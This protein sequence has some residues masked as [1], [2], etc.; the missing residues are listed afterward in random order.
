MVSR[1][2]RDAIAVL[3]GL[4]VCV[5]GW[6]WWQDAPRRAIQEALQNGDYRLA[7]QLATEYLQQYPEDAQINVHAAHACLSLGRRVEA[8]SHFLRG[9]ELSLDDL[10]ARADNLIAMGRK[11][12]AAEVLTLSRQRG[13][14]HFATLQRL[15][16]LQFERGYYKQAFDL[17]DE[18]ATQPGRRRLAQCLKGTF[19]SSLSEHELAVQELLPA[20]D[21]EATA[22]ELGMTYAAAAGVLA[23]SLL[24]LGRFDE[25]L[26]WSQTAMNTPPD[27]S[28]LTRLA[29]TYF[30]MGDNSRAEENWRKALQLDP[31]HFDSLVGMGRVQVQRQNFMEAAGWLELA[32][33]NGPETQLLCSSLAQVYARTDRRELAKKYSEKAA[34]LREAAIRQ[35]DEEHLI[36]TYPT[37]PEA[38]TL[39]AQRALA[40][41]N[42]SEA[43]AI[44]EEALLV[45]PNDAK[46]V[47]L[48]QSLDK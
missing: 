6:I 22:A 15:A 32:L 29:E 16:V 45:F 2:A 3:L 33:A 24:A 46:L 27:V 19:H 30:G 8:E 12:D 43:R 42:I 26:L 11:T 44:I 20:L 21:T 10:R 13:D 1:L 40:Q 28:G 4:T 25:A 9:G 14:D 7:Y 31:K 18:L 23:D 41:G 17:V 48:R 39:L 38:R 34:Q 36:R 47:A 5:G 37:S 35:H